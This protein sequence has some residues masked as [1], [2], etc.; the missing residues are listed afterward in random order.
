MSAQESSESG[1]DRLAGLLDRFPVTAAALDAPPALR[2]PRE[3]GAGGSAPG[4]AH[5]HV[6]WQGV[7]DVAEPGRAERPHRVS[8]PA[9][10]LYATGARHQLIPVERAAVTC[11]ALSFD[12]G[13]THPIARALPSRVVAPIGAQTGLAA[14]VEALQREV[15]EVRCGYR[16]IASRLL[17]VVLLQVLRWSL[18][19]VDEIGVEQGLIRGLADPAI[20]AALVAV[21]AD[22]G[23]PWTLPRMAQVAA[24]SRS[25]FAARF[26]DVVGQSPAAYLAAYRISL[27]QQGLERGESVGQLALRLGY[28]NGSG[29]TRAFSASVGQPPS[30]W[31]AARRRATEAA[32]SQP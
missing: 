10:V 4:Y 19:R 31:L 23:G 1:V 12:G 8:G 2:F 25:A 21:H 17:E 3:Y 11:A 7:V 28:S 9:V 13:T 30:A 18:D 32:I 22:P 27:A 5:L 26:S 16:L 29:L 6:V 15:S 24:L 20:A 14:S